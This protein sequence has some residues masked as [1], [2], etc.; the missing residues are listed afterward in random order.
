MSK[1]KNI[2]TVI[3][4]TLGAYILIFI[5]GYLGSTSITN[6]ISDE[7][8][9]FLIISFLIVYFLLALRWF[10]KQLVINSFALF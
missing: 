1:L 8:F 5:I 6:G 9:P 10:P 2:G 4:L 3:I 7:L